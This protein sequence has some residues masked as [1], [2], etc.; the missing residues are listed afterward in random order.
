MIKGIIFD[1]DGV[2]ANSDI[3][4]KKALKFAASK[5]LLPFS[6]RDHKMF[7]SGITLIEGAKKYLIFNN[8]YD[9]FEEFLELKKSF[10]S[11]YAKEVIPFPKTLQFIENCKNEYK[12]GICSGTRKILLNAFIR[13]YKVNNIFLCEVTVE[14]F[15]KG[16]PDPECYIL[17][18]NKLNLPKNEIIVIEDS[19]AGILSAKTAGLR[20]VAVEHTYK[21]KDLQEADIIVK[22]LSI[23]NLETI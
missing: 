10:D 18:I 4:H 14:D 16:K 22:D 21:S 6:N 9:K 11:Q 23:L 15:V 1:Y 5:L 8:M 7:F 3:F 2:I 12:M 13:R 19:P 20:C 17:S